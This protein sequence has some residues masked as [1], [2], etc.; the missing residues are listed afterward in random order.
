LS[1]REIKSKPLREKSTLTLTLAIGVGARLMN[2][3]PRSVKSA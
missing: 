1:K 3:R 2:E